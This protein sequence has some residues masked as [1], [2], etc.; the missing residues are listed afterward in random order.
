MLLPFTAPSLH[1]PNSCSL[2]SAVVPLH[3]LIPLVSILLLLSPLLSL[4]STPIEGVEIDPYILVQFS[5][6]QSRQVPPSP[7]ALLD[8][9][10]PFRSPTMTTTLSSSGAGASTQLPPILRQLPESRILLADLTLLSSSS[11][12]CSRF[13]TPSCGP[14]IFISPPACTNRRDRGCAS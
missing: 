3:S 13:P 11:S 5:N 8:D 12:S 7:R 14:L 4:A 6:G 1:P 9:P 2:T 10:D